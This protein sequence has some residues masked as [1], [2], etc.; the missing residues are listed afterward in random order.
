M[1][2]DVKF[3]EINCDIPWHSSHYQ[4]AK[5]KWPLIERTCYF[6]QEKKIFEALNIIEQSLTL[7]RKKSIVGH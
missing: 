6:R 2:D 3:I 5:T 4:L 7:D 1:I